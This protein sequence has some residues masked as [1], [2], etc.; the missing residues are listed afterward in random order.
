MNHRYMRLWDGMIPYRRMG[1]LV[2]VGLIVGWEE[3]IDGAMK[4]L[5]T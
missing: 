2:D 4:T 1:M 5:I 3:E